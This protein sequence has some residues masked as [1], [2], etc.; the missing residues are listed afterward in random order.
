MAWMK[1][2]LRM[3][4][5][6]DGEDVK[7]VKGVKDEDDED[8]D[9]GTRDDDGEVETGAGEDEEKVRNSWIRSVRGWWIWRRRWSSS[10]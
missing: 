9:G 10:Q 8:E 6:E 4:L 2:T 1:I 5:S 3:R 7:G